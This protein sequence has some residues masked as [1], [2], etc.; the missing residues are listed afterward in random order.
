MGMSDFHHHFLLSRG[1]H[2]PLWMVLAALV[3]PGPRAHPLQQSRDPAGNLIDTS[4]RVAG[5]QIS[6]AQAAMMRDPS[7]V[8]AGWIPPAN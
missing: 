2:G 1:A 7:I 8:L 4:R 6:A 3:L 5:V